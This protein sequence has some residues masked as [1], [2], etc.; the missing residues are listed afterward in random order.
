ML[1]LC[2]RTKLPFPQKNILASLKP[3]NYIYKRFHVSF[4]VQPEALVKVLKFSNSITAFK[5]FFAF[6]YLSISSFGALQN[7]W[8]YYLD[9]KLK[10]EKGCTTKCLT[11][12]Y[13]TEATSPAMGPEIILKT[14]TKKSRPFF[15]YTGTVWFRWEGSHRLCLDLTKMYYHF[16]KWDAEVQAWDDSVKLGKDKGLF[17]S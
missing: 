6:L 2:R 11:L 14:A 15:L 9:R 3:G 17:S 5:L 4:D 12:K 13:S 10:N 1:I 8:Q 7:T 16:S